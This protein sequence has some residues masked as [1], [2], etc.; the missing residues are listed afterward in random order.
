MQFNV[1]KQPKLLSTL[2]LHW[3]VSDYFRISFWCA[4]DMTVDK[5]HSKW[6]ALKFLTRSNCKKK[7]MFAISFPQRKKMTCFPSRNTSNLLVLLMLGEDI[8]GSK[9]LS[10]NQYRFYFSRF[11]RFFLATAYRI[12]LPSPSPPRSLLR[13]TDSSIR[14]L[15]KC[16]PLYSLVSLLASKD[17]RAKIIC[18][19]G[20][21]T[22]L[23]RTT[24]TNTV[25]NILWMCRDDLNRIKMKGDKNMLTWNI[26]AIN[27]VPLTVRWNCN[28]QLWKQ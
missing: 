15:R 4:S 28:I 16:E 8:F 13:L 11:A 20:F 24:T 22:A 12:Y 26:M 6:N 3:I 23:R 10:S 1:S 18:T 27:V 19:L 21:I 7:K 14:L 5:I 9:V 2:D 25:S 17:F